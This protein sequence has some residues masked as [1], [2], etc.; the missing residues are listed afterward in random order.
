MSNTETAFNRYAI[1][2][3]MNLLAQKGIIDQQEGL[4][5]LGEAK[6]KAALGGML[7]DNNRD[8]GTLPE[9][10]GRTADAG[11]AHRGGNKGRRAGPRRGRASFT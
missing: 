8:I 5:M 3:L 2:G 10:L 11:T 7:H 1:E 4:D 6:V 9:Q